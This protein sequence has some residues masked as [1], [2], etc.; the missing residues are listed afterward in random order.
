MF[1]GIEKYKQQYSRASKN[2]RD[3]TYTRI[4]TQVK[5]R[6]D[7]C[8]AEFSR[9]LGK[10]NKKRLNNEYYHVCSQCD[11][12]KFAQSKGATKRKIWNISV[13]SDLNIGDV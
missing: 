3:H 6:C 2:G 10:M 1:M 11:Y 13:D 4:S 5:L 12:K 8:Q 9:P 7:C